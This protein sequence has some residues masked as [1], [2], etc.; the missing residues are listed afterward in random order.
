MFLRPLDIKL[1]LIK[2]FLKAYKEGYAFENFEQIFP[3]LID[4]KLKEGIFVEP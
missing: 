3:K 2:K 4:A 1:E